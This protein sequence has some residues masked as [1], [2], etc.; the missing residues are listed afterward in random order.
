M[1]T[2]ITPTGETPQLPADSHVE[3]TGAFDIRMF[4]GALMALYGVILA[5][6]GLFAFSA[7]DAEKTDGFNANLWVGV[8]LIVFGA[9][10]AIWA[11]VKP[12]RIVVADN[13][14]GAEEPKDIA[15]L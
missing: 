11:K 9:L 1:S 12:I 7:A 2:S 5:A 6:L 8:G 13:E 4:I 3:T 14:P 15:A 10:M